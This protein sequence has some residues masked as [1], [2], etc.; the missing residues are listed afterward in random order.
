MCN[1]LMII[2]VLYFCSC[3]YIYNIESKKH[4]MC[5][6]VICNLEYDQVSQ[7]SLKFETYDV[8]FKEMCLCGIK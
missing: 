8:I 1:Y 4:R 5:N 2:I 3:S 6:F 7:I